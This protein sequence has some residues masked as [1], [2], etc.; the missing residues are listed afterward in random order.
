MTVIG[1][2]T[3]AGVVL[4]ICVAL[5]V[6]PKQ[7]QLANFMLALLTLFFILLALAAQPMLTNVLR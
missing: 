1:I 7:F 5:I 4:A 6:A 2:V 3:T